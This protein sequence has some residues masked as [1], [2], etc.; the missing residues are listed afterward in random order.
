MTPPR[1][2]GEARVE[3]PT[4]NELFR[5]HRS[6]VKTISADEDRAVLSITTCRTAA[7]GGCLRRCLDCDDRHYAYH[8][9]GNRHCPLCQGAAREAWVE[10]RMSETLPVPYFHVVFTLMSDL[11]DLAL[12]NKRVVYGILMRAAWETL[13]D[14]GM[15][16][17]KARMAAIMILHTWGQSLG[18]HPHVHMVVPGGGIDE[19]GRWRST[20]ERYLLNVAAM[21]ETFR[22]KVLGALERAW[23]KGELKFS[24]RCE[25]LGR[26]GYFEELLRHCSRKTWVVKV[27]RPFASPRIVLRYLGNYTHRVAISNHRIVKDGPEGVTFRWKDYADGG[28][29]KLMTLP[30]AQFFRRF[31][32]HV[33]PKGFVRI[34]FQ[35]WMAHPV[36]KRNVEMLRKQ[37]GVRARKK[38]AVPRGPTCK[39]CGSRRLEVVEEIKPTNRLRAERFVMNLQ[40]RH[41]HRE[42]TS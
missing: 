9:C 23:K 12:R 13:R 14:L 1:E 6:A 18:H 16:R 2:S 26:P 33:L 29:R 3:A 30:H 19:T 7:R 24:G 37:F 21:K 35:G 11:R 31:L 28:R 32:M 8:S 40:R 4:I 5:R 15:S 20:N 22:A 39:K 36:I 17:L 10:A 38:E 41:K 25:E 42:D 27:R 34:R